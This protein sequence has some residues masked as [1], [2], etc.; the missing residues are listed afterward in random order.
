V[1]QYDGTAYS[2]FQLQPAPSRRREKPTVQLLLEAALT[3]AT[4]EDRRM[5]RVQAAGRTDAGVHARGQVAQ[6]FTRR[7]HS[8]ATLLR[9]LNAMLPADVRC[10]SVQEV[11]LGGLASSVVLAGEVHWSCW[12]GV[13]APAAAEGS[14]GCLLPNM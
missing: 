4:G 3:Q 9:A 11:P 12:V 7:P 8:P 2:G 14:Q 6:L 13:C 5:L 1:L 10:A